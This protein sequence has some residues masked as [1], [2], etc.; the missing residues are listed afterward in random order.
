LHTGV[1]A[2]ACIPGIYGKLPTDGGL[3]PTPR[4]IVEHH[5]LNRQLGF[6]RTY[7][8]VINT[9]WRLPSPAPPDLKLLYTPWLEGLRTSSRGQVWHYNDC[10]HRAAADGIDWVLLTDV[11]ELLSVPVGDLLAAQAKDVDVV[12]IGLRQVADRT[13]AGI[14]AARPSCNS[15]PLFDGWLRKHQ[16]RIFDWLGISESVCLGASG[17][18]K[19]LVRTSTVW[20]CTVHWCLKC[21]HG[22]C[23][24]NNTPIEHVSLFETRAEWFPTHS[25]GARSRLRY[26]TRNG[27]QDSPNCTREA[28]A[29]PRHSAWNIA[30]GVGVRSDANF[31]VTV[32]AHGLVRLVAVPT[33]LLSIVCLPL[34]CV[35]KL[36]SAF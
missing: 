3:S 33:V 2:A 14:A 5:R 20:A 18:R 12:S 22:P 19:N 23:R 29:V 16:W 8:Y 1:R 4:Q 9:T 24:V 21:I 32:T 30:A 10:V 11:D 36:S 27:G 28:F 7:V 17:R 26:Y 34:A 25:S 15:V 31:F 35:L 6:A 13:P